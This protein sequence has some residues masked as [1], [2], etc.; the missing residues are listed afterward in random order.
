MEDQSDTPPKRLPVP[1]PGAQNL[2][3]DNPPSILTQ[4]DINFLRKKHKI[5]DNIQMR[6]PQGEERADWMI[7][8]WSTVYLLPFDYGFKLPVSGLLKSFCEYQQINPSQ[9]GPATIRKILGTEKL[10]QMYNLKWDP[11]DFFQFYTFKPIV[12]DHGRFL[13]A[14]NQNSAEII[15]NASF[16]DKNWMDKYFFVSGEWISQGSDRIPHFWN[17]K[18]GTFLSLAIASL[19][20]YL[21]NIDFFFFFFSTHWKKA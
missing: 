16:Q 20:V 8:G 9:L 18:P 15:T 4:D 17:P 13:F 12:K 10:T 7:P 14:T 21:L 19:I 6:L 5:P 1:P 3:A 2:L 11:I